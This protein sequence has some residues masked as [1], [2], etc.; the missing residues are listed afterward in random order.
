MNDYNLKTC[1]LCDGTVTIALM[2]VNNEEQCF[3]VT[4]GTGGNKCNCSLFLQSEKFYNDDSFRKKDKI[5]LELIDK[6]NT[7]KLDEKLTEYLENEKDKQ[8]NK[9]DNESNINNRTDGIYEG[10]VRAIGIVKQ[11]LEGGGKNG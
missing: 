9:L 10:L 3:C 2:D 4:R 7:R 11:V 5:K 6:W 8:F 1:P